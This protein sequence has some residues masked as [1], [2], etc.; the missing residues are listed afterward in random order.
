MVAT[1]TRKEKKHS[2]TIK[3]KE[4]KNVSENIK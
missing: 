1:L 2:L 4:D 3:E